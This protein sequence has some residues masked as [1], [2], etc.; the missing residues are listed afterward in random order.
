MTKKRIEFLG[1]IGHLAIIYSVL[2]ALEDQPAIFFILTFILFSW[3]N[4]Y[5][6]GYSNND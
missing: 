6:I 2:R 1:G 3:W 4:G 5:L